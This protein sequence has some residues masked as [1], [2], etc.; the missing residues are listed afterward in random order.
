MIGSRVAAFF[1]VC[2]EQSVVVV[3]YILNSSSRYDHQHHHHHHEHRRS[4]ELL[5]AHGIVALTMPFQSAI[6]CCFHSIVDRI[7]VIRCF[8]LVLL[9]LKTTRRIRCIRGLVGPLGRSPGSS[10]GMSRLCMRSSKKPVCV[11]FS[12]DNMMFVL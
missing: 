8:C 12:Y 11:H 2:S 3:V 6:V 9:K 10:G 7:N 1:D 5:H 4:E